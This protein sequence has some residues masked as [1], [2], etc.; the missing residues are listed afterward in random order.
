MVELGLEEDRTS[1]LCTPLNLFLGHGAVRKIEWLV[2]W[3]WSD[4]I[5]PCYSQ[6]EQP[7]ESDWCHNCECSHQADF[8]I[9]SSCSPQG[10]HRGTPRA[11]QLSIPSL[12]AHAPPW[13]TLE[14]PSGS[15]Q[16]PEVV[17]NASRWWG[18]EK[19][20]LHLPVHNNLLCPNSSVLVGI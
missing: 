7:I 2:R 4:S 10:P 3:R 6:L 11:G 20:S 17:G 16:R 14:N 8:P 5:S 12:C 18:T 9:E 15:G 1:A 13:R 19:G